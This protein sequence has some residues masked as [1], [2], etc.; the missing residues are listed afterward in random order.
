MDL[1][2]TAQQAK[3]ISI[4]QSYYHN[5]G[6]SQPPNLIAAQLSFEVRAS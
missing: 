6:R 1:I 5:Y 4:S 2:E 3:L